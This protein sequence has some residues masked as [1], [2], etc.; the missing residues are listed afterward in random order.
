MAGSNELLGTASNPRGRIASIDMLRGLVIALMM[1][2]H[3]RDFMH[4]DALLFNPTDL[5]RT[6]PALFLTRW[7]TH[8][9]AP[10]F[11]FL[12]GMSACLQRI[13]G[14]SRAELSRWL[15]NRGVFL[16][17]LELIVL[18]PLIWFNLDYSLLAHL[19]VI[20]AIGWSMILLAGLIWL[21]V[22]LIA[23]I[24]LVVVAGHNSQ[25]IEL[26]LLK[27]EQVPWPA[28]TWSAALA[29]ILHEERPIILN[30]PIQAVVFA[31]YP[32]V[33]WFAVMALGYVTGNL[34]RLAPRW[35]R[36]GLG[37]AGL[38]VLG[39]FIG[40][41]FW[42]VYGDPNP[43]SVPSADN[44]AHFTTWQRYICSFVNTEKYPPSLLFLGMTLGPALLFL[45]VA[46]GR[47]PGWLGKRLI[48]FGSVPLFFY[49]LQWP[50]VHLLSRLFQWLAG[51]PI[52]WDGVN[53][54][55]PSFT[56]PPDI[57]FSLPITYLGWLLGLLFLYPLCVWFRGVKRRYP[58][59]RWLSYL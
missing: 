4:R 31:H 25:V 47:Q 57:G 27:G 3:A 26:L 39:V 12:A 28:R 7:L 30:W 38:A 58:K 42:N 14:L 46:D 10:T 18:R 51:Q 5:S 1:L 13:R 41:R 37:L 48:V 19:Q 34:Y 54:F 29:A 55:S 17:L 45:A 16:I 50:T 32:L 56:V 36:M 11:V 53:Q 40:L 21:P 24:G 20:W 22:W 43:W 52:G 44:A 23:A 49:V 35:R 2:D 6:T 33:P 59:A 15:I 9:C 8:Y